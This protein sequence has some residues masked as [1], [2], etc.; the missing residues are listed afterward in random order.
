VST[1]DSQGERFRNEAARDEIL[2]YITR[3]RLGS[4]ATLPAGH[5]LAKTLGISLASVR[6]GLQLLE[7]DGLI[8]GKPGSTTYQTEPRVTLDVRVLV[9][10]THAILAAGMTPGARVVVAR[11]VPASEDLADRFEAPVGTPLHQIERVR[12]VDNRVIAYERSFFPVAIAPN[13][14]SFDMEHS[15]YDVL[16]REFGVK[17]FRA[18]QQFGAAVADEAI[19]AL[20]DCQVG[21]PLMVVRRVTF[22]LGGRVVEHAVDRFLPARTLFQ[23]TALVT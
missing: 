19:A 5:H 21:D 18:E 11:E 7:R 20:L 1:G 8:R 12:Y 17:L 16:E 13:L 9:S 4:G 15:I 23:S 6:G 3:E 22:E 2:A 14:T 10:L